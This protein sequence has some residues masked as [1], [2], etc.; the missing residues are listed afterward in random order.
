MTGMKLLNVKASGEYEEVKLEKK[1]FNSRRSLIIRDDDKL[2]LEII[3]GKSSS[4]STKRAAELT[5]RKINAKLGFVYRIKNSDKDAFEKLL[6]SP[7]PTMPKTPIPKPTVE[8]KRRPKKRYR[9]SGETGPMLKDFMISYYEEHP[10]ERINE[11]L[12]LIG[13]EQDLE[14]IAEHIEL[15]SLMIAQNY[16]EKEAEKQLKQSIQKLLGIFR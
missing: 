3:H 10:I 1:V 13:D 16:G 12:K 9:A 14:L 6:D 5:A 2:T 4:K 8:I 15:I 11:G 7:A